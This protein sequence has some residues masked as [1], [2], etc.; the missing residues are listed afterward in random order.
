MGSVCRTG[1][2]GSRRLRLWS[3]PSASLTEFVPTHCKRLESPSEALAVPRR[4]SSLSAVRPLPLSWPPK[5]EVTWPH[6]SPEISL[7]PSKACM[8]SPKLDVLRLVD[9]FSPVWFR[10][11]G[12]A[13]ASSEHTNGE[14]HPGLAVGGRAR[15]LPSAGARVSPGRPCTH[16]PGSLTAAS[17]EAQVP[18]WNA[19][20]LARGTASP[21]RHCLSI[22]GLHR[23]PS[24]R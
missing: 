15:D 14:T 17:H 4:G 21:S 12:H 11:Q 13:C 3:D 6:C 1:G 19:E 5:A 24:P 23:P 2:G 9:D 7:H 16:P 10:C 20:V 22:R 18:G 8:C